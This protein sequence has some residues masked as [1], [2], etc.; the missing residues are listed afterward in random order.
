MLVFASFIQK[1]SSSLAKLKKTVRTRTKYDILSI[2]S[3]VTLH[4]I[5]NPDYDTDDTAG[6]EVGGQHAG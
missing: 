5:R 4:E 1:K 6:R 2:S 3:M